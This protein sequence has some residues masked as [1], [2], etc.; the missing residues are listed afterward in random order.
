MQDYKY[1][2]YKNKRP[3][4]NGFKKVLVLLF[5]GVVVAVPASIY[6]KKSEYSLDPTKPLTKPASPAVEIHQIDPDVAKR[7]TFYD[8]L[9]TGESIIQDEAQ[10]ASA[11]AAS[12][13]KIYIQLN[14]FKTAKEA[15]DFQVQIKLI[16]LNPSIESLFL[17]DKGGQWFAVRLGPFEKDDDLTRTKAMLKAHDYPFAVVVRKN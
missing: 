9:A 16:D 12:D 6:F 17:D 2:H 4:K 3:K 1:L 8:I 13:N 11:T 5:V 7:F 14:A 15:D 10:I